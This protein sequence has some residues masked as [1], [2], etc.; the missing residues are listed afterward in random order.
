[1]GVLYLAVVVDSAVGDVVSVVVDPGLEV[2]VGGWFVDAA[3]IERGEENADGTDYSHA[4]LFGERA[5]VAV[6][7]Q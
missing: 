7:G 6:V 3:G 4:L 1:M 5:G 2:V